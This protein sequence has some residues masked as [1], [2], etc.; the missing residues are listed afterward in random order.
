MSHNQKCLEE[1]TDFLNEERAKHATETTNF[2]KEIER[3]ETNNHELFENVSKIYILANLKLNEKK[4][5]IFFSAKSDTYR[6]G[7]L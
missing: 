1:M 5:M 2:E 6:F 7:R 3:L 4:Q